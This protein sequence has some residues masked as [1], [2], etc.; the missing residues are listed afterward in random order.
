MLNMY[1]LQYIEQL[2]DYQKMTEQQREDFVQNNKKMAGIIQRN[3]VPNYGSS[4]LHNKIFYN[5]RSKCNFGISRG[6]VKALAIQDQRLKAIANKEVFQ[7]QNLKIDGIYSHSTFKN[8]LTVGNR[9]ADF[10][11]QK[12]LK[13]NSVPNS[14]PHA[15]E[16][17]KD[18]EKRGLS[19]Y[20]IQQASSFFSKLY[21]HKLDYTSPQR[22]Y[23]DIEK[24][25]AEAV[26]SKNFDPERHKDLVTIAK[27]TGGRRGD[28]QRLK[29]SNFER[30]HQGIITAVKFEN[31]KGGRDRWSPILPKYQKNVTEYV[32]KLE[33]E[34]KIFAFDS[35]NKN[36]NIHAY[37]REYARELYN[38]VS[39]NPNYKTR[40]MTE[41]NN[42]G[43]EYKGRYDINGDYKSNDGVLKANRGDLFIVSQA[44]GHNRIDVV[45]NHYLR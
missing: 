41:Y 1:D 26:R 36:A 4:K 33:R 45:A 16:Y 39:N 12:G 6:D 24:G 9:F 13:I 20:S 23:R 29:T 22:H 17:L 3:D 19:A 30:N 2:K 11:E 5:L 25:R 28:L 14:E 44:L 34:K 8:Y 38:E 15:I 40:L 37:R 43:F 35:I 21:G 42:R 10:C 32:N 31:S 18:M 7:L 27:A